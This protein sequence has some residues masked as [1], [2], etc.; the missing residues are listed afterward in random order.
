V[1]PWANMSVSV[2]PVALRAS[3]S[4]ARCL[5]LIAETSGVL[6]AHIGLEGGLQSKLGWGWGTP[7]PEAMFFLPVAA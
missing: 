5:S 2:Q 6:S 4:R 7:G 1:K 3:S